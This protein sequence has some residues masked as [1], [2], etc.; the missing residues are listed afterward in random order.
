MPRSIRK[1]SRSLDDQSQDIFIT[2]YHDLHKIFESSRS[3]VFQA[4]RESD[5]QRV[6]L[7]VLQEE[8]LERAEI[9]RYKNQFQLLQ[10]APLSCTPLALGLEKFHN[11]PM[12][13]FAD[14]GAMPLRQILDAGRLSVEDC[15]VI[16]RLLAGALIEIHANNIIHKDINP[17]NILYHPDDKLVHIIDFGISTKLLREQVSLDQDTVT[18]G[19][20]PYMSPEQTGRMNRFLDYRSDLYSLGVTLYEMF[21]GQLPF[22]SEDPLQLIHFHIAK[23]QICLKD[24][25]AQIPKVVSD[26][27]DKLL[28]KDPERR[29]QSAWGLRADLQKCLEAYQESQTIPAFP[30][31]LQDVPDKFHIPET[32][33]G[34]QRELALLN[35]LVD[36]VKYG[37]QATAFLTGYAGVGKSSLVRE[38]QRPVSEYQGLFIN[39]KFEEFNR[40]RP[41]S[42]LAL[43]FGELIKQILSTNEFELVNWRANIMETLGSNAQ[44]L[45]DWIPELELIIGPQNPVRELGPVETENRFRMVFV[46]FVRL[47]TKQRSPFVLYLDDLQWMDYP[48]AILMKLLIEDHHL[49]GLL[50]IGAYRHEDVGPTHPI[51][52]L[53][54]DLAD[55][56]EVHTF[57]LEPLGIADVVAL[58]SDALYTDPERVQK[59]AEL[60]MSKTGGNPFFTDEFLRS[61]HGEKYLYFNPQKGRWDW[62]LESIQTHDMTDNIV[63]LMTSK[64]Q[65]LPARTQ[66]LITLAACIG[67]HFDGQLL[68]NL[69][70]TSVREIVTGLKGA[71]LEGLIIPIGD[72]YRLVELEVYRADCDLEIIYKFAHDRILQAAR[73]FVDK[74]E[75][76]QIHYQ[77]GQELKKRYQKFGREDLVFA[78]VGHLNA[79]VELIKNNDERLE[80]V[81]FNLIAAY[82]AKTSTAY[83]LALEFLDF[84][85]RFLMKEQDWYEHYDLAL[86]VS[87]ELAETAELIGDYDGMHREVNL[88][89]QRGRQLL[90]KVPAYETLVHAAIAQDDMMEAVRTGQAIL[91]Q[92]GMPIPKQ[93]SIWRIIWEFVK[94]KWSLLGKSQDE[95]LNLPA[96]TDQLKLAQIHF[97]YTLTQCIFLYMPKQVPIFDLQCPAHIIKI[98]QYLNFSLDL[99]NLRYHVSWHFR[100]L[101]GR[102]SLW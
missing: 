3:R 95:L 66:A 58:I 21:A 29:Y 63:Q 23:K 11:V 89:L 12:L 75:I 51:Q 15:L 33:Y 92:L 1:K 81:R 10:E 39:G 54:R 9:A 56:V 87:T 71:V 43:A 53:L 17:S 50:L 26:I 70:G 34:R 59:L 84:V 40:N 102:L 83:D 99:Y 61:L 2:G 69:A 80:L 7:K 48:S 14:S 19:S 93:P 47:I 73:D 78:M 74:S 5:G 35:S 52:R 13:V 88:V 16:A 60:V 67:Q 94:T 44:I 100:S 68:A 77:V 79:A 42:G 20:L 36:R 38:L 30:L 8:F 24:L 76:P 82:R 57:H 27:V 85:R 22:L 32:L 72:S 96:L 28:C 90:D 64:I 45:V 18:E 4:V 98:W 55:G 91:R 41:Y 65:K 37:E 25:D 31:A 101:R 49:K 46:N 86:Q 97:Q 6:I 62:D